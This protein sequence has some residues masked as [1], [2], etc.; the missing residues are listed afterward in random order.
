MRCALMLFIL[1]VGFSAFC[2]SDFTLFDASGGIWESSGLFRRL[3]EEKVSLLP[4][5]QPVVLEK[6]SKLPKQLSAQQAAVVSGND[7]DWKKSELNYQAVGRAAVV[8]AVS[9]DCPLENISIEDLQRIYSG[10]IASWARFGGRDLPV[11][12]GGYAADTPQGRVFAR[13]VM[14]AAD[15]G[16][17]ADLNSQIAPGMIVCSSTQAGMALLRGVPG[18]IV[19]ADAELM[20]VLHKNCK[21]LKIA[22]VFPSADN[23][24]S[25]RYPLTVPLGVV[26]SKDAPAQNVQVIVDFLKSDLSEKGAVGAQNTKK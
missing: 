14:K 26:S 12:R 16:K 20:R 2:S 21:V 22:G 10:R 17:S 7:A 25:G 23:I 3:M 9:K 15:D 19:F 5:N 4:D 6:I 11:R 13:L 8:A 24:A 18:M 1:S